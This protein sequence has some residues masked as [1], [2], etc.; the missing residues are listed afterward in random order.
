[1]VRLIVGY[2]FLFFYSNILGILGFFLFYK[3]I[4]SDNDNLIYL[5]ETGLFQ[6][7]A[8]IF[9][10]LMLLGVPALM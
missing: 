4:R 1:M 2:I 6:P 5:V 7:N 8:L 9:L 3:L 10:D